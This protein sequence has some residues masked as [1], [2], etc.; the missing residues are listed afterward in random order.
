MKKNILRLILFI[1]Y[2]INLIFSHS[3]TQEELV[4]EYADTVYQSYVQVLSTAKD[5]YHLQ[6]LKLGLLH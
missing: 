5:L 4:K 2:L 3:T 1:S 6:K